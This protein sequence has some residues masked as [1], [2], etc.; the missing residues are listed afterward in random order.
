MES[1]SRDGNTRL[2]YLPPKTSVYSLRKKKVRSKHVPMDW[3]QI[4]KGVCQ[5]CILSA[6][7]FNIYAEYIIKNARLDEAQTEIK[8]ARKNINDFRYADGTTI[9]AESEELRTS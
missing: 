3:F 6:C 9:M 2:P 7:S 5:G 8:I 4:G 1:P